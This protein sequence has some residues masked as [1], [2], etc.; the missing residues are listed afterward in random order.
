MSRIPAWIRLNPV[1]PWGVLFLLLSLTVTQFGGLNALARTAGLRAITEGHTLTIDNY[2]DWT[3][4]WSL[5]PSGHYYPNKAPG[6][7]LLG[8]P[9]FALTELIALPLGQKHLDEKGRAPQPGYAQ[10]IF[11]MLYLQ[12]LPFFILVL[13]IAHRMKQ[14]GLP[15]EAVHFFA[16][17]ALFGNTAA[18]Y[19]N[20][21]FGH[22]L[23]ALLLLGA[24]FSWNERRYIFTGLF[25]SWSLLSDYGVAFSLPFF[26]L[27][28]ILREKDFRSQLRIALGAA[29]GAIA[30][31]WY[32]TVAF[33]SPF[34][35]ANQFINPEQIVQIQKSG[36]AFW[37]SF[38]L[39]PSPTIL[40]EL[41][42]GTSRGL[43]FTQPWIFAVFVLPFLKT[44]SLPKGASLLVTGSLAGLLWM[45]AGFGGW[46]GGWCLGPR[47]LAAVLPMGALAVA[48]GWERFPRGIRFSLWALLAVSLLFRVLVFPF[49]S[50]APTQNLWLYHLGLAMGEHR[51]TTTLRFALAFLFI[52]ATGYWL[53]RRQ[54]SRAVS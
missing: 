39:L 53:Y 9:A 35:T 51:G 54:V 12:L 22:G 3:I 13:W 46:H 52:G 23:A 42:F 32:H 41:L 47:Y 34:A 7:V 16:L 18:L 24:F 26:L 6:P 28:T 14:S 4:D 25:L 45:N 49:S 21:N 44:P 29:P 27:A 50:L 48:F 1:L 31:I 20:S 30:W 19:M 36:N 17:A 38:S 10:H 8:L 40:F 33:G 5:S 11:L 43:L 37:D 15:P 2:K